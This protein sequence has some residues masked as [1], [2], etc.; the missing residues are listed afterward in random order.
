MTTRSRTPQRSTSDER[1]EALITAAIEAFAACGLHGTAV[2]SITNAV[3]ITQPY[4]FCLFGSKKGLFLAAVHRSFDQLEEL[5]QARAREVPREERL[6]AIGQA[7]DDLLATDPHLLRFHL[8]CFAAS[9]DD[10][11]RSVVRDR[12]RRLFDLVRQ[13]ADV[14]DD[15]ARTFL[16]RGMLCILTSAL[17]LDVLAPSDA[18]QLR[19]VACESQRRRSAAAGV[20]SS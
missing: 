13:V 1:R 6:C 5:F 4:A 19:E 15:T 10:E 8:Q 7:Y 17:D 9:G 14:D 2:S 11:V 16:G 3:G 20:E 12:M 18:G